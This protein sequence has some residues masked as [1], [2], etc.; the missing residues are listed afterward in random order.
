MKDKTCLGIIIGNRDFF[1]D[2]L[3]GECR[4]DLLAAFS[5]VGIT[6]I[7]LGENETKLGGV[8]TF[9]EAQKCADLFRKHADEIIGVLVVLPNFG[10]EKGI[11]ETLKLAALNVPVLVQ[12]Y[13]D[14]LDKM[15]VARRRDAW[16]GKI[17]VCNNLY[18]FGIKFTLTKQR[19]PSCTKTM[20]FGGT[21]AKPFFTELNRVSPP[22]IIVICWLLVNVAAICV[23]ASK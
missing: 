13:P 19:T 9:H 11:A 18:Q 14:D 17:S 12:A 23:P 10:D 20:A 5:K 4:S 7:M 6:P 16:C 3:V 22:S 15:D 8:E 2:K 1:P 21:I